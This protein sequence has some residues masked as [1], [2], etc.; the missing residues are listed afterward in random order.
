MIKRRK[1]HNILRQ[2]GFMLKYDFYAL[3]ARRHL[4]NLA[5]A[6][7]SARRYLCNH[8]EATPSARRHLC[9]HAV[10]TPSARRHLCNHAV[11]SPSARRHLCNHAVATPSARRLIVEITLIVDVL[12]L[13]DRTLYRTWFLDVD[14]WFDAY[15]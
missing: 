7:R 11:A 10:A 4:C 3:R 14:V 6:T 2:F 1:M 8:A 15:H 13:A 12:R 9:N 5:E